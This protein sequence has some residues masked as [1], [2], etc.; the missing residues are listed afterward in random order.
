MGWFGTIHP[1]VVHLRVSSLVIHSL[2]VKGHLC[3]VPF[4]Y[5][6]ALTRD[7]SSASVEG[8]FDALLNRFLLP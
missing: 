8:F 7:V 6:G 4:K 1:L 3:Y 5:L 2:I